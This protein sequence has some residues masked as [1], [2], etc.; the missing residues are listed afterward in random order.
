MSNCPA[1]QVFFFSFSNPESDNGS[2]ANLFK[3]SFIPTNYYYFFWHT[4]ALY[5]PLMSCYSGTHSILS[6][7]VFFHS[8][9]LHDFDKDTRTLGSLFLLCTMKVYKRNKN[10]KTSRCRLFNFLGVSSCSLS[11]SFPFFLLPYL[12]L[13]YFSP[14]KKPFLS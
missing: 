9:R 3:Q 7:P 2:N 12:C 10:N 8:P 14:Q 4:N 6:V 1:C 5:Y 11:L 13:Y